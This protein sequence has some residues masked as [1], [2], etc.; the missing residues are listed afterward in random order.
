MRNYIFGLLLLLLFTVS[1]AEDN[2]PDD[3]LN[4]PPNAFVASVSSIGLTSATVSWTPAIDPEGQSIYYNIYLND[5]LFMANLNSLTF[6]I[7]G[8]LSNHLYNGQIIAYDNL[9][10]SATALFTFNTLETSW[11]DVSTGSSTIDLE[12]IGFFTSTRGFCSGVATNLV[13]SDDSGDSWVITAASGFKDTDFFNATLGYGTGYTGN[14]IR[15]TIDGGLSWT[16]LSPAITNSMFGAY[17]IDANTAYFVGTE[18]KILK[19]DDA[20]LTFTELSSGSGTIVLRDVFFSSTTNGVI[21]A[22]DG[23]VRHT[24]DG[25]VWSV[26]ATYS[27]VVFNEVHFVDS[28]IG[29][30]VGTNGTLI[31]TINGGASWSTVA[32]GTTNDLMGVHFADTTHGLVV[33]ANGTI[34]ATSDGGSTWNVQESPTTEKYNAVYMRSS[35]EAVIVGD[36]GLMLKNSNIVY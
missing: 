20:G 10:L 3:I 28:V 9:G 33:G 19:T 24:T 26:V 7:T 36:N 17:T 29:F 18:G 13:R 5:D 21:I 31:K 34:Y 35:I 12:N 8:L 14:T 1:C 4:F 2:S 32:L 30:A 16:D 11:E 22:D 27:G 15:K 23:T 25:V 6:D